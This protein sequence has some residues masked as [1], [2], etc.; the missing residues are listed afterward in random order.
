MSPLGASGEADEFYQYL[1]REKSIRQHYENARLLYIG[2]TRAIQHLYL[3]GKLKRDSKN[4][5]IKAPTKNTLFSH[6]WDTVQ[7]ELT[8][9][10]NQNETDNV[11]NENSTGEELKKNPPL[12]HILRLSPH[13]KPCTFPRENILDAYRQKDFYQPVVESTRVSTDI[14]TNTKVAYIQVTSAQIN[15][16]GSEEAIEK[17]F[18][19]ENKNIPSPNNLNHR[20]QRY[21]GTVLHQTLHHL[22]QHGLNRW[23]S[24]RIQQQTNFWKNQLRQLGLDSTQASHG[25]KKI[26][27]AIENIINDKDGR[28]LLDHSHQQSESELSIMDPNAG[29]RESIIDRSFIADNVRWIVD[30]KSSEPSEGQDLNDFLQHEA[31]SYKPQLERYS[32]VMRKIDSASGSAV[33]IKTA[34]YFPLLPLLHII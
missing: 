10:E 24:E 1:K 16:T 33:T 2:C 7:D 23:D 14:I 31:S 12:Q 13:W 30:F 6:L 22:I 26:A 25:V 15:K 3:I 17:T 21:I 28:W 5:E 29:F 20:A 8:L 4:N 11:F 18:V 32:D 27:I 19:T 34:L 9:I